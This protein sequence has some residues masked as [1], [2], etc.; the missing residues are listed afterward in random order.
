MRSAFGTVVWVVACVGVLGAIVCLA[1]SRRT[2]EQYGRDHLL[3]DGDAPGA[4][5]SPV[6]GRSESDE[7]VLQLLEARNVLRRRRG[8]TE[9]DAEAE[10]ARLTGPAIDPELRAEIRDLVIARNHRRVRSG[11]PPLDVEGEIARQ[12]S[13]LYGPL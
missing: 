6:T 1:L 12:I 9:I 8:Q 3:R 13:E 4:A 2:W 5:R 11:Q 10:L 7:E